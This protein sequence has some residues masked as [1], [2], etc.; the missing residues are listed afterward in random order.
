MVNNISDIIGRQ[1]PEHIQNS[2]PLF[3]SFLETYY[4]YAQ[5]RK[6]AIGVIQSNSTDIDIDDTLNEYIDHFY[7]TYGEH[8]PVNLALDKRNFIKILNS[9]YDAKGS[10]KSFHLMFRAIFNKEIEIFTPSEQI[11]R[12][13][14]GRW[15]QESFITIH[16]NYG[17]YLELDN[18]DIPIQDG[19]STYTFRAI[20]FEDIGNSNIR[21]YFNSTYP[22][23]FKV[24]YVIDIIRDSAIVFRSTITESPEKLTI[25]DSGANFQVGQIFSITGSAQPTIFKIKSV[26]TGGAITATEIL[27]YGYTHTQK[28]QTLISSYKNIPPATGS[29]T[30]QVETA[31]GVFTYNTTIFDKLISIDEHITGVD[32]GISDKTYF[33]EDYC[34]ID[35]NGA[36]ILEQ[37][38][39]TL[40]ASNNYVPNLS[41]SLE[42]YLLDRAKV[43]LVSGTVSKLPGRYIDNAG[44]LSDQSIKLHD[45]YYYQLFSY[46]IKSEIDISLYKD[47]ILSM[48]HP[49]GMKS[50]ASMQKSNI[51]D[52][53]D[54]I[55]VD[56]KFTYRS[57]F[58][59]SIKAI[60]S[61]GKLLKQPVFDN[62]SNQSGYSLDYF[63]EDYNVASA[64]VESL[65][66][67]FITPKIDTLISS[68]S[69]NI[70]QLLDISD[71]TIVDDSNQTKSLQLLKID[72]TGDGFEYS[73]D[74]F[75][76]DYTLITAF[77]DEL[78]IA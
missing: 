78:V 71:S 5:Q 63:G 16:I 25:L 47:T 31:P 52:I 74:Y 56:A 39:N 59:D 22:I 2:G 12:S 1:I 32:V 29:H 40:T 76:E 36:V 48:L 20:R 72:S 70:T 6:S 17:N 11:L 27:N 77:V 73:L 44:H 62:L 38:I 10:E 50:F 49:S 57:Y 19:L 68:D 13:S 67:S 42:K 60:E 55:S 21:I 33:L 26:T 53:T 23:K 37:S 69:S 61:V 9:I 15:E 28:Q 45:S 75:G 4:K 54:Y 51:I 43:E 35:Y 64:L 24:G 58:D 41:I 66:K 7:N 34:A 8:L 18:I 46:V 14:A 65:S 30:I 3:V